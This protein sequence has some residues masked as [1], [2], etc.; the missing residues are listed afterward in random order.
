MQRDSKQE[1]VELWKGRIADWAR[2]EE[3]IA[4]WVS[5]KASRGVLKLALFW[6]KW[7]FCCGDFRIQLVAGKLQKLHLQKLNSFMTVWL[8]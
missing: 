8:G 3:S 2:S 7:I 5:V 4:K 6:E 1:L